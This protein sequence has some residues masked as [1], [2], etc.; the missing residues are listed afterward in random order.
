MYFEFE[1]AAA[2]KPADAAAGECLQLRC[3]PV[4]DSTWGSSTPLE[5]CDA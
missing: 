1:L 4:R 5:A 2:A 3:Y